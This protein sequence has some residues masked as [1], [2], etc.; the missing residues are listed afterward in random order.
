MRGRTCGLH[1]TTDCTTTTSFDPTRLRTL[2]LAEEV[3]RRCPGLPIVMGGPH[4]SAC[5]AE[6]ILRAHPAID[7]AV[8][9]EGDLALP[10]LVAALEDRRPPSGI[11]GLAFR[12]PDGRIEA[13][14]RRGHLTPEQLELSVYVD[15]E[16]YLPLFER[17]TGR[18][19]ISCINMVTS[20]GCPYRCTFCFSP[21]HWQDFV[22]VPPGTVVAA[23]E[24]LVE[25]YGVELVRFQDDTNTFDK[26][27]SLAIF[28]GLVRLRRRWGPRAPRLYM[29][30]Y[31]EAVDREI[32]ESFQAAGG[33]DIFF[34]LESGSSKVRRRMGKHFSN[35]TV[36][37][38][39]HDVHAVGLRFGVWL[40][41][42]HPAELHTEDC[43]DANGRSERRLTS[44]DIDVED[45]AVLAETA[46]LIAAIRP[47]EIICNVA[48]VHPDTPLFRIAQRLGIYDYQ[49]W[50]PGDRDFF[51]FAVE[52]TKERLAEHWCR[53]FS[54]AGGRIRA[55]LEWEVGSL[56]L[57]HGVDVEGIG[58]F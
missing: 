10:A 35:E 53:V 36:I 43:I 23:V 25:S 7:F 46:A 19:R 29:H 20:R 57:G 50:L 51:P 1:T 54:R 18:R 2:A 49:D 34:G 12:H 32:L 6:R 33:R 9:G 21:H 56:P 11:D 26:E 38:V 48:H 24:R 14:P 52:P 17:R 37:R 30:T 27:R 15:Y 44:V 47:H 5:G 31:F 8:A 28:E 45:P 55:A 16:R 58:Q 22:Y 3:R 42:G 4:V 40:I 39:A 41:F 13:R